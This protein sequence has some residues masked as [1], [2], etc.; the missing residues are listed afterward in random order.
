VCCRRNNLRE[1]FYAQSFH[2]HDSFKEA[3]TQRQKQREKKLA[4]EKAV[5]AAATVNTE[6]QLTDDNGEELSMLSQ[7]D[8]LAQNNP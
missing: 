6:E 7:Y 8:L 2:S 1:T 4:E 5:A 3:I